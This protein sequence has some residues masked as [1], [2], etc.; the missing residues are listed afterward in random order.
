M[1]MNETPEPFH[2]Y[3][4]GDSSVAQTTHGAD[5]NIARAQTFAWQ[6][7]AGCPTVIPVNRGTKQLSSSRSV[8]E[9]GR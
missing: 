9:H 2:Y 6:G 8:T 3:L 5:V 4:A 1:R 7:R